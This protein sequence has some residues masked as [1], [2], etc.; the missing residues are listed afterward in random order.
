[1]LGCAP[2]RG[3]PLE[4]EPA[5][6]AVNGAR[7]LFPWLRLFLGLFWC[8]FLGEISCTVAVTE[9]LG[10]AWGILKEA[11][12]EFARLLPPP[13]FKLP[14]GLQSSKWMVPQGSC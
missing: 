6:C 13:R 1:M 10:F 2:A 12:P 8:R 14:S 5:L 4:E 9:C 3:Q 11:R 7:L